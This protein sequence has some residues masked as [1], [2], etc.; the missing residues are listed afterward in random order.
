MNI[1]YFDMANK[2]TDWPANAIECHLENIF[3]QLMRFKEKPTYN[4]KEVLI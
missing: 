4:N 1:E 3:I 2:P